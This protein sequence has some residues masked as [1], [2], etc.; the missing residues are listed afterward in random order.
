MV[1]TM[2]DWL[3]ADVSD[4][5]TVFVRGFVLPET[6]GGVGSV[7]SVVA[8]ELSTVLVKAIVVIGVALAIL[9]LTGG[10]PI[11]VNSCEAEASPALGASSVTVTEAVVPKA[12]RVCEIVALIEVA[13]PPG[14]IV[15]PAVDPFQSIWAFVAKLL[16]VAVRVKSLEPAIVDGGLIELSMGVDPAPVLILVHALTRLVAS[17]EPSPVA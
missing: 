15:T 10:V 9:S 12:T 8:A 13:V 2:I 1:D 17:I 16:P 6:Q 7:D 5:H 3:A 11:T 4:H 14:S